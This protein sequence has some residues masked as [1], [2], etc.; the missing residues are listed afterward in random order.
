[1]EIA[2]VLRTLYY[3]FIIAKTSGY[4]A[5]S[6]IEIEGYYECFSQFQTFINLVLSYKG[7]KWLHVKKTQ[8]SSLQIFCKSSMWETLVTRQMMSSMKSKETLNITCCLIRQS[9]NQ[10]S[11]LSS[12]SA[13]TQHLQQCEHD[14]E[15]YTKLNEFFFPKILTVVVSKYITQVII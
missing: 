10:I 12:N 7:M 5:I 6:G 3:I 15:L 13:I 8:K 11:F 14:N 9:N 1:M 2:H 4:N